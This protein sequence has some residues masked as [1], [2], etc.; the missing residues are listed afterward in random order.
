MKSFF[1]NTFNTFFFISTLFF[2]QSCEKTETLNNIKKITVN[3]EISIE[4]ISFADSLNGILCGGVKDKSGVIYKTSDGGE[5]WNLVFECVDKLYTVYVKNKD[6][7]YVAGDSMTIAYSIDGGI[8]WDLSYSDMFEGYWSMDRSN[9]RGIS[10]FEN[11]NLLAAGKRYTSTGD[12]YSF[13][14][15]KNSRKNIQTNFSVNEIMKFNNKYYAV[16][17][18]AIVEIDSELN[19]KYESP[20]DDNFMDIA[21]TQNYIFVCGYNGSI[22]RK[23]NNWQNQIEA[24]SLLTTSR[25]HLLNI[26]FINDEQG[27]CGG[28]DGLL[29][30]TNNSGDTWTIKDTKNALRITG[31]GHNYSAFFLGNENGELWKIYAD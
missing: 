24:N 10:L 31:M 5:S 29:Y 22:Y 13:D 2:I 4:D 25:N 11:G 19:I 28:E 21:C 3:S 9:I 7:M 27:I 6:S 14:L 30:F 18:G 20:A 1:F 8:N 26:C 15:R 17:Y 16:G 12:I 23:S